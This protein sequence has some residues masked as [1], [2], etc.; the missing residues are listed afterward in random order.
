MGLTTVVEGLVILRKGVVAADLPH[1]EGVMNLSGGECHG[2][3]V[4]SFVG[5]FSL[6][7]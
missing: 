2:P 5:A 7:V 1:D 3:K 4:E 6:G